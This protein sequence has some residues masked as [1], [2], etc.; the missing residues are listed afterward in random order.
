VARIVAYT[1]GAG[2]LVLDLKALRPSTVYTVVVYRG[3]CTAPTIVTR[4]PG[5]RT[6]GSGAIARTTA[7]SAAYMN[8]IWTHGRTGTIAL[9]SDRR[10][11]RCGPLTYLLRRIAIPS[12]SIDL[13]V[14]RPPSGYRC[15]TS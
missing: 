6:D 12:L 9:R 15:A 8:P 7:L 2:Q 11:A 4:L 13:P 14:I 5:F 10:L 3:T 1:S